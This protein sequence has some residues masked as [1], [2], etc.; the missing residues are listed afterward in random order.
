[1][2][3]LLIRLTQFT[4]AYFNRI[5]SSI[6]SMFF[7]LLIILATEAA[8]HQVSTEKFWFL[9]YCKLVPHWISCILVSADFKFPHHSEFSVPFCIFQQSHE[10]YCSFFPTTMAH[11]FPPFFPNP[12]IRKSPAPQEDNSRAAGRRLKYFSRGRAVSGD[13]SANVT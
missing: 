8:Y 13:A 5:V 12:K 10:S 6:I 4:R 9:T 2:S 11:V 7:L 1:M 3:D